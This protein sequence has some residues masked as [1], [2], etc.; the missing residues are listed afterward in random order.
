MNTGD[1]VTCK[2]C[3]E[4]V[5]VS[6]WTI[7]LKRAFDR[8]LRRRNEVGLLASEIVVC[9]TC[10][11]GWQIQRTAVAMAEWAAARDL[12][13]KFRNDDRM[14][15]EHLPAWY[16]NADAY[17]QEIQWILDARALRAESKRKV[18]REDLR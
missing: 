11:P 6:E 18:A 14:P 1:Q 7:G 17:K 3:G 8:V 16:R 10:L 4:L 2:D 13:V 9:A 5:A 12:W 15:R